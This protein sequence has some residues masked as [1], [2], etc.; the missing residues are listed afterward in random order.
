MGEHGRPPAWVEAFTAGLKQLSGEATVTVV[1][2]D[3]AGRLPAASMPRATVIVFE[4]GPGPLDADALPALQAFLSGGRGCVVLGATP[5]GWSAYPR[6]FDDVLGATAG[7]VFAGGAPMNVI[8]LYPHPIFSGV[9][10]FETKR[11]MP[12]FNLTA[13]DVQLIMEGTVGEQTTPLGWV[14]RRAAGRV[15]HLVPSGGDLWADASYRR[16]VAN[17]VL[18]SAGVPI[19]DAVAGVQRTF[20]PE[21][22]P[23]SIALTLPNGPSVCLDP[24][25]GG[26]NYVW[27]GDF[28]DLRPRWL[29]KQGAPARIFGD[30]FYVEKAW[31]PLR[32]G[33]PGAPPDFQFRGYA[34]RDG[35][36]EFHYVVGGRDVFERISSAEKGTGIV[37][38]FRVGAGE[39]PLWMTLESQTGAEVILRGLERDGPAAS[40]AARAAGEFT[41]EIRRREGGGIR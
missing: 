24:V 10:R 26:I 17:A 19:A 9:P 25:R 13:G 41:I 16:L 15:V 34:L 8:S 28:V 30:V 2:R 35:L 40:Y 37:R 1:A 38:R 27:D 6:F 33:S 11:P 20:M 3:A 23:G 29:T 5:A 14:R 7:E 39:R 18:W 36:P 12:A 31:Q 32:A 4:H 22:Y 21:S